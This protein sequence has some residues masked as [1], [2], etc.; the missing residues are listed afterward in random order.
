MRGW[1]PRSCVVAI[2]T[3]DDVDSE[4][5]SEDPGSKVKSKVIKRTIEPMTVMNTAKTRAKNGCHGR[6]VRYRISTVL[7]GGVA[8]RAW[9][10]FRGGG[11]KRATVELTTVHPV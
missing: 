8:E 4:V 2:D 9:A 5:T 3:S 11:V 7:N 10:R 6:T 1:F